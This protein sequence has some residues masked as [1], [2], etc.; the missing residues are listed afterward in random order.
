MIV[1]KVI[2]KL[3]KIKYKSSLKSKVIFR[4]NTAISINSVF[5]GGNYMGT[6][7]KLI[8]SYIGYAS[9]VS[10]NVDLGKTQIGRY[11][12]IAPDV[13]LVCGKH[14]TNTFVSVHP[15]FY[16]KKSYTGVKYT[17]KQLFDEYSYLDKDKKIRCRIGNDVWIGTKVTIMEGVTIG[18]GAIVAAG[19]VVTK[20]VEPYTIVGGVPAKF[21]KDRFEEQEKEFLLKLKWWDKGEEWIK[22]N[23]KH[24]SDIKTFMKELGGI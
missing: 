7:S 12:C 8:D 14:P 17:D 11:T 3:K 16:A 20:D 2:N 13:S 21:I 9:Y 4:K 6:N 23:A 1:N 22:Q 5:E 24:F 10:D 19:S 15:A 18:D